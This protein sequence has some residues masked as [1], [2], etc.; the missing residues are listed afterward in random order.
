MENYKVYQ[1][2]KEDLKKLQSLSLDEKIQKT[3]ARILEWYAHF[4]GKVYVSFSGGKD[5]TVLLHMARKLFPDIEAVF[6]DTGL[7]YP[8]IREFVKT[9][10]N[11]TVLKPQMRFDEVIKT[12]GYPVVSKEIAKIVYGALYSEKKKQSYLNKLDGL[13]PD[14]TTSTFK[15]RYVKW[16]YL[17][18]A[19]YKISN[20][21]CWH[22]KEKPFAQFESKTKLKCIM[23]TM[24]EDSRQRQDGWIKTGCNAFAKQKSD[25]EVSKPISFWT[26]QDILQYIKIFNLPYAKVYGELI[27]KDNGKLSFTG[28]Q[29]TGCMFCMF[30]CHLE[31]SPNR[32]QRMAFTHPKQYDYCIRPVEENGLG[33]GEVLDYI[34]VDYKAEQTITAKDTGTLY[35]TPTGD[36]EFKLD[37][38]NEQLTML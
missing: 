36:F 15:Q 34:G 28:C 7:E 21:C 38:K 6:V 11:V 14:F 3:A 12:Y 1:H 29:R 2:T 32:F 4:D 31:K 17:L 13:N 37:N 26:E 22:M 19:P 27:Q 35:I 33:L 30:G 20:R 9:V 24:A 16:K 10:D 5:S 23:G 18:D 8:E 25:R